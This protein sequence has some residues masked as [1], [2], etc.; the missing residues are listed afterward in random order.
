[1]RLVSKTMAEAPELRWVEHLR[2][3]E[4]RLCDET[5][6]GVCL[7]L[8]QERENIQR[9]RHKAGWKIYLGWR[10][11]CRILRERSAWKQCGSWKEI[12]RKEDWLYGVKSTIEEGVRALLQGTGEAGDIVSNLRRLVLT[13]IDEY[14]KAGKKTVLVM[15]PFFTEE[16][17]ADGYFQ[18]VKAVD[19]I[20]PQDAMKIYASWLDADSVLGI[21]HVQVWDET[22]IEI[23]YFHPDTQ[24]DEWIHE[25]ARAT[26]VVYHHSITFANE[27]VTLD[28]E[29]RKVF[30]M[31]GAYPEELRMYGRNEQAALDEKQEQLAMEHG[32]CLVCVTQS[33]VEHLKKKYGKI[34]PE[35]ILLPIFDEERLQKCRILRKKQSEKP[36]VVYAGGMQKWQNVKL[37]QNAVRK[38]KEKYSF[39]FYTPDSKAFWQSW[40]YRKHPADMEVCSKTPDEVLDAYAPCDYGFLLRE[41]MIINRV[42]CPTKLVEYMA[43]GIV[44]ILYTPNIGDFLQDGMAYVSLDDFASGKSLTEKEKQTCAERNKEVVHKL[45]MRYMAGRQAL[46]AWFEHNGKRKE[47]E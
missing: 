4:K 12:V 31:H 8:M 46:C 21:P 45:K 32:Q 18:R 10:M 19:S 34:P 47:E 33:M 26:D 37:M 22:H 39:R 28:D 27:L 38:T 1:M 40:G 15:A 3:A 30:D 44:P 17:L 25:I 13:L 7:Q 29:I 16:R 20:L 14:R 24:N 9:N 2:E 11:G 5:S 23:R 41:D 35:V 42:A 6:K 43:A 36:V